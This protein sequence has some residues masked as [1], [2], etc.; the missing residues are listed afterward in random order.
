MM[1]SGLVD[2]MN[3][4]A[5]VVVGSKSW[6][7]NDNEPRVKTSIQDAKQ[8]LD[9]VD[10]KIGAPTVSGGT[11]SSPDDILQLYWIVRGINKILGIFV[12]FNGDH[13]CNVSW[14]EPDATTSHLN[15]ISICELVDLD[16]PE[17]FKLLQ[18]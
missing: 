14:N 13:T 6:D 8:F 10:N 3:S 16:M 1:R 4:R 17:K 5:R 2:A 18:N 15:R 9:H 7:R 11:T 12:T